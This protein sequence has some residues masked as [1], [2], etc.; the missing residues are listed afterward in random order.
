MALKF[1]QAKQFWR[2]W[3]KCVK[4]CFDQLFNIQELL[5]LLKFRCNFWVFQA[6]CFW[7]LTFFFFSSKQCWQL[8]VE[9]Q[10]KKCSILVLGKVPPYPNQLL[11]LKIFSAH[12]TQ[13]FDCLK[14][15]NTVHLNQTT[16][17]FV[18]VLFF[19]VRSNITKYYGASNHW[20]PKFAKYTVSQVG[21]LFYTP[22][23]VQ[24][25]V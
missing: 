16:L 2:Y 21:T 4:Y 19:S 10:K 23:D 24:L 22:F 17:I 8:T 15:E 14:T 12:Y 11:T 20:E 1:Q 13:F 3:S 7:T 6:I 5:G 25:G 9:S 18:F